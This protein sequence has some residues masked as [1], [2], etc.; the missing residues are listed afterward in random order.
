MESKNYLERQS[1]HRPP[2]FESDGFIYWKNR[3]ETYV[4]SKDLDLWHVITDG[5]FPPIQNNPESKKDEVVPFHK[6]NDDLK[7]KLAKN[8]K[9]KMVIYNAL[10]RKEYERI[11]MCQ[12]AKEIWDT[13][14]IT[15]Q[16]NN[17]VKANKIDLLAQQYEQFMIPEE[18]SID[19]AFAKF[20]TI[21]TSLKALDEGFSSKNCVRKFL[22]ALHPKWCAKVTAIEESK[23]LTTLPLNE[24]IGNM[25]VYEEVIKK[26]FETIKGKKKQSRSLALKVKKEPSKN[27]DQRAFIG[28]AWSDNGKDEV[29]KTKEEICLVAQAPDEI[30]LRINLEPNEWIKDSGCSIHMTGNRKLFSSYKA[31]N[32]GNVI[33]GSNLR[34]KIIDYCFS[35]GSLMDKIIC[36][37]NKTPDL[38]QEPP[39]NCPKCGNP[40]DGHYCQGYAL[41]QKKFKE[42]L[43]TYCIENGIFQDIFEPSNDNTNV[44]NALQEPFVVKQDPDKNSSQ[45][46]HY[47]YNCP[48]K[49]PI[50]PNPK[51]CNNQIID[52]LPQTLSS[53]DP[54]CYSGDENSFTYDSKSNIVDDFPNVFNPPPQP[55]TYSYEFCGNDAYYGHDCP[56]QSYFGLH[57][58]VQNIHE[59]LA[60]YVNTP[61]WD[62]PTICYN[63]DDD[64]DCTI[65][66]TP[67]LST[68]E[69]DNSLSMGDEH[70]DTIPE[71]ESDEL[72]KSSVENLVPIPSEISPILTM[73]LLRLMTILSI[74]DIK[75]VEASPPVSLEV[76][77]IVIPEVGGIDADILLTI[78][79]DILREKLLNI[80]L[81][82]D[83]IE[84]LKVNPTPYFDFMTKSSSTS[85][86]FLLEETNTFDNS[87]PESKISALIQKRIVVAVPLLMTTLA[88]HIIVAR[89]ENRPLM[90]EKS[91]YDSWK[92][93]KLTEAQQ[94]QDDCN[95][96][97]TN[98]IL[99]SFPLD[100]YELVNHQKAAKDIWDRVKMLMNDTE[101]S[102]Q[103][104]KCRLYNLF[105]KFAHVP[106]ETLYEYYWRFSQLINDMHTI[107][108]TMQQVQVNTKFLNALPSEWRGD[109]IE[110]INKAMAFLSAVASRVTV[111]QVQKRQHQSYAGTR[112]RGIATTS[113]GNV[114]VGPSRVVKCYNCQG[115]GHMARQ[116][117]QP[118]RPRNVAWLIEKLMLAKAQEAGQILDE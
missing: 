32:R 54:T 26:D 44:A 35:D 108:M 30:C 29:E 55:L 3:F 113:K 46:A 25:K 106:G 39:Q 107:G 64:E 40:V 38:F 89:A 70:L 102:Y 16:D 31:Y 92:Y 115:E 66:I 112:N 34:G 19:N 48:S 95:V 86:N 116:F 67:I 114:T 71:T 8:N 22:R 79:D 105:D 58:D 101:L 110:C 12:T 1:M 27:N 33:F 49:V 13:L 98:I 65:A 94:L 57:N 62:R 93:S 4:K 81:L 80:N 96:Q 77:E 61:S 18:E 90:L 88:E 6:Q 7:K 2:L 60:V 78:K 24:L 118:K 100:V 72:I 14:L 36:D 28:G 111:Q 82:I 68:E 21:I 15:H 76:M 9:A 52:E 117:T 87:L 10:P 37:L 97:A 20:N 74:D 91:M 45:S 51:P 56:L 53:F 75:Y 103:E 73:I 109:P 59:E 43:F 99:H 11:F 83:I 5:D 42:D 104:R 85:L 84:A 17:E 47:G 63:N 69:P 41:L 23:N 50:I